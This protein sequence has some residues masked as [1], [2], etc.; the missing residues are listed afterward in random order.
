MVSR[1]KK[2]DRGDVEKTVAKPTLALIATRPGSLQDSL[3]ALMSTMHQVQAVLVAEDLASALRLIARHR[4]TLV[5]LEMDLS[6]E[7]THAALEQ[8]KARWPSARC[9]ALADDVQQQREAE[10]AGADIVLLK[11]FPA[12]KLIAAIE[13]LLSQEEKGD[14]CAD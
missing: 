7:E 3:V 11:G 10:A 1:G 13:G 2:G 4:P 14:A 8:I 6:G 5:T 9:I 12:A